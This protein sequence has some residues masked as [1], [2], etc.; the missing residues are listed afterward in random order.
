[1]TRWNVPPV[2]GGSVSS[3]SEKSGVDYGSEDRALK[4]QPIDADE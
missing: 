3:E 1:L 4:D 2:G